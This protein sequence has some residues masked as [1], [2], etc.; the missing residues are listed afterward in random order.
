MGLFGASLLLPV[1]V[2][3]QKVQQCPAYQVGSL[4]S[5]A[6][7]VGSFKK[8]TRNSIEV[9]VDACYEATLGILMS[10]TD[11]GIRRIEKRDGRLIITLAEPAVLS[12]SVV[13]R[14]MKVTDRQKKSHWWTVWTSTWKGKEEA[15]IE[16]HKRLSAAAASDA[17]D[18][19]MKST[20]AKAK[21]RDVIRDHVLDMIGFLYGKQAKREL[22]SRVDVVFEGE[23]STLPPVI[24]GK[25]LEIP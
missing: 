3:S 24:D 9:K 4:S 2:R 11:R 23:E 5:N 16:A 20:E 22:A 13:T 7:S 14:S 19:L 8:W 1:T 21:T 10:M 25:V 6:V 17:S 15:T 18:L 12:V